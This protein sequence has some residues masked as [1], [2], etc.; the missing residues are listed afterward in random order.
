[1]AKQSTDCLPLSTKPQPA[2]SP[3]LC[4]LLW[5]L[6]SGSPWL[7]WGQ[8]TGWDKTKKQVKYVVQAFELILYPFP[9]GNTLDPQPFLSVSI[10]FVEQ[11]WKPYTLG[12]A[13]L[14]GRGA[15]YTLVNSC[16]LTKPSPQSSEVS[17]MSAAS[18]KMGI[19]AFYRTK[20]CSQG[21]EPA[22]RKGYHLE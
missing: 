21:N 4:L 16:S 10:C 2:P 15:L 13:C 7:L 6:W 11:I 8:G 18:Q 19:L 9:T 22:E 3:H 5:P 12:H 20:A 1:M 17:S 14:V